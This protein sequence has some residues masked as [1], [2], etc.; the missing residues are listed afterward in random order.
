MVI[1][2]QKETLKYSIIPLKTITSSVLFDDGEIEIFTEEEHLSL[3]NDNTHN[4]ILSEELDANVQEPFPR[5]EPIPVKI[6]RFNGLLDNGE[7]TLKT[8]DGDTTFTFHQTLSLE[9]KK[10]STTLQNEIADEK[11]KQPTT[12]LRKDGKFNLTYSGC[13]TT[14]K[15]PTSEKKWTNMKHPDDRE[16]F[17]LNLPS[18]K[19][20]FPIIGNF[21]FSFEDIVK[22]QADESDEVYH[23]KHNLNIECDKKLDENLRNK[24]AVVK[25]LSRD[26]VATNKSLR[27]SLPEEIKTCDVSIDSGTVLF[28]TQ[29][30]DKFAVRHILNV[31]VFEDGAKTYLL[32]YLEL[33][34]FQ[35]K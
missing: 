30:G 34:K 17:K 28:K 10:T 33:T 20:L 35:Y 2:A 11:K 15:T 32:W 24:I 29:D 14:L 25:E 3:K 4:L 22:I 19:D 9:V 18:Y 31:E 27:K 26:D 6:N 7:L 8:E 1:A 12:T 21:S 16:K 13:K 23:F 5:G